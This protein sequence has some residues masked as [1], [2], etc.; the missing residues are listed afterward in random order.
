LGFDDLVVYLRV[1]VELSRARIG[2]RGV[3]TDRWT[4]SD[5]RAVLPFGVAGI[6]I[7]HPQLRKIMILLLIVL[8]LLFG[9]GGGWYG[10]REGGNRNVG[11][12]G[13]GL[14]TILVIIVIVLLFRG[15]L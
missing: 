15:G 6:R 14:G 13:I 5:V 3:W 10:F 9:G 4:R 11:Y 8:I 7:R 12:G 1:L 2:P